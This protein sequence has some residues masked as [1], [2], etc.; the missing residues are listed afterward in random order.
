MIGRP[1]QM[2]C[3]VE[4]RAQSFNKA[5]RSAQN[6]AKAVEAFLREY[7]KGGVAATIETAE[8]AIKA[9]DNAAGFD[10][11]A[12]A[13]KT[14]ISAKLSESR[15]KM[16]REKALMAG[17][18]AK[19]LA[20]EGIKVSG[21]LPTLIAGFFSLEFTFGSKG[22]CTI[23]LG[24]GK[25]RLG[26]APL[27]PDAICELVRLLNNQYFSKSFDEHAFLADLEKAYRLASVRAG[28]EYG[29]RIAL[30]SVV[31]EMA[32][33]RQRASFMMDPKK[34]TFVTYGRVEFAADLSRLRNRTIG[35]LELR[36]DVATMSQTKKAEEHLWIP[37]PGSIE[38]VN[39]ATIRFGKVAE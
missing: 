14:H 21:N 23:W 7:I 11:E 13:L 16:D 37:R 32:F 39:F 5:A 24:P 33:C 38:G 22:L 34:E 6:A 25:Y 19:K 31:A 26:T 27:D 28:Q 4:E 36:L 9:L 1:P 8:K 2:R 12:A 17:A 35:D 15:Q 29:R 10:S 30:S 18:V 3:P 20:E